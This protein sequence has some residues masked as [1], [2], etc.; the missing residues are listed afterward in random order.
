MHPMLMDFRPN[1]KRGLGCR[2]RTIL[3]LKISTELYF[4]GC[5]LFHVHH[6]RGGVATK[7]GI[8]SPPFWSGLFFPWE[9]GSVCYS[10]GVLESRTRSC[11]PHFWAVSCL[12]YIIASFA[13]PDWLHRLPF[14]P[15]LPQLPT[16]IWESVIDWIGN[17]S[18]TNTKTLHRAR[19][20]LYRNIDI[21]GFRISN[22]QA[23]LRTNPRLSLLS[24]KKIIVHRHREPISALLAITRLQNLQSLVLHYLDLTKEHSLVTRGLLSRSVMKLELWNFQPCTISQLLRFLSSFRSLTV[25]VVDICPH[26]LRHNGR[27]LPSLR[28]IPSRSLVDLRLYV[29]PGLNKLIEWYIYEGYFLASL[30]KLFLAWTFYAVKADSRLWLDGAISL[31]GHCANTLEDLSLKFSFREASFGN[32]LL[33]IGN[34]K[35]TFGTNYISLYHSATIIISE[36]PQNFVVKLLSWFVSRFFYLP[37]RRHTTWFGPLAMQY[38]WSSPRGRY[39]RLWTCSYVLQS[40]RRSIDQR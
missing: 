23:T 37:D 11:S 8:L 34:F 24:T 18:E 29:V 1:W 5:K 22:F 35:Y 20:H 36:P 26:G 12:Q 40:H 15:I 13:H 25:L 7:W 6:K 3:F 28:P 31:L 16:E 2:H 27:T 39:C 21:W 38:R 10:E 32:D 9:M 17:S 30:R 4:R 33:D 14:Y 19:L